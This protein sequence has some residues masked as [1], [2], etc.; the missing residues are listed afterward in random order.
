MT[1]PFALPPHPALAF[2]PSLADPD[3]AAT[4]DNQTPEIAFTPVPRLRKRRNGWSAERQRVFIAA[5]AAC[6]S[7]ARAARSVGM[8]PR[9]AYRLL[10]AEGADGFAAAWD[11]AIES[12][13]AR[14]RADALERAVHG[15]PVA[16]FRRGK[17]V[18]VEQRRNDRLAIALLGGRERCID[19][20]RRTAVARRAYRQDLAAADAAKAEARRKAEAIRAEHQAILDALEAS[21]EARGGRPFPAP[22]PRVRRL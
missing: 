14:V 8:T 10:D 19:D 4:E 1:P 20:Y 7:V 11:E 16:L 17:L 18:R 12:G 13:I 6:G 21:G 2:L 5:L 3:S 22:E 9:S 15:A